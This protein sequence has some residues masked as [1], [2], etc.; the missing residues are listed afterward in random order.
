MNE[1]LMQSYNDKIRVFPAAPTNASGARQVQQVVWQRSG[2]PRAQ[3]TIRIVNRSTAV[4]MID[5]FRV[6]A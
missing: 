1:S 6:T 3:H 4:G 2:L 5:A